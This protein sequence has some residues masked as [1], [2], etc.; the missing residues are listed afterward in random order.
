M[1]VSFSL[2]SVVTKWLYKSKLLK[3]LA[4]V[5]AEKELSTELTLV[6]PVSKTLTLHSL[7]AIYNS[8]LG[9]HLDYGDVV[10][11]Q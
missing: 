6:S 2:M 10:Y 8:F 5:L 9:P 11:D 3:R 4:V 1:V 7:I